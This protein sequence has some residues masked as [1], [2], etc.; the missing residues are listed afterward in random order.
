MCVKSWTSADMEEQVNQTPRPVSPEDTAIGPNANPAGAHSAH[1]LAG[2]QEMPTA[3]SYF[4]HTPLPSVPTSCVV[5]T[6]N[7]GAGPP[8]AKRSVAPAGTTGAQTQGSPA[9]ATP[10]TVPLLLS[11]DI[12]TGTAIH[13]VSPQVHVSIHGCSPKTLLW[14]LLSYSLAFFLSWKNEYLLHG[15]CG[16]FG[17]CVLFLFVFVN[18]VYIPIGIVVMLLIWHYM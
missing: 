2:D 3:A 10:A 7:T 15:T 9:R 16:H 5:T 14:S 4:L 13:I 12:M 8:L 6:P 11:P 17:L 18:I 1:S